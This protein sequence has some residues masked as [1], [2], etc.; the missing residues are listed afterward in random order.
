MTWIRI[1]KFDQLNDKI[2]IFYKFFMFF[3]LLKRWCNIYSIPQLK[4]QLKY[5]LNSALKKI[6]TFFKFNLHKI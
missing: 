6:D 1:L 2:I 4:Y 5:Q 3:P